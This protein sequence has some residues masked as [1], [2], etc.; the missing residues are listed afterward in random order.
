MAT[1]FVMGA[2]AVDGAVVLGDVEID[3]PWAEGIGHDLISGPEFLVAVAF[4]EEC[5][6]RGVVAHEVEVGV[7][8]VSLKS[9]DAR[10]RGGFEGVHRGFPR[11]ESAPADFSFRCDALAVLFGD[12]SCLTEGLRDF[13]GVAGDVFGEIRGAARGIDADDSGLADTMRIQNFSNTAGL[14][15]GEHEILAILIG[16]EGRAADGARPDGSDE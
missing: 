15:H 2:C 13:C 7:G 9:H 12:F 3:G 14:F 1:G 11:V 4:L 8:E 10:H 6:F 5:G 16:T